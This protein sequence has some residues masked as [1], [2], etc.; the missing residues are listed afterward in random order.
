VEKIAMKTEGN[1]TIP[2]ILMKTGFANPVNK[3][4]KT[5]SWFITT[6]WSQLTLT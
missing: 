1:G 5:R 2:L 3:D 6:D 4:S